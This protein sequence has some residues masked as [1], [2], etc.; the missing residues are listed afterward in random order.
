LLNDDAGNDD[1]D[2]FRISFDDDDV[3]KVKVKVSP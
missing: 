2:G 1:C 3:T